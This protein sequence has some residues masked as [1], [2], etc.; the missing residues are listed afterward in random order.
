MAGL[1]REKVSQTGGE[2]RRRADALVSL[3]RRPLAKAFGV[4][5]AKAAHA[6]IAQML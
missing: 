5:S 4:A 1:V 2:Y 3:A 6:E